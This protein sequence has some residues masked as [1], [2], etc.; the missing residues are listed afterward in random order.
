MNQEIDRSGYEEAFMNLLSNPKYADLSFYSF[1]IAK[2]QI[3]I[4]HSVPTAGAGFHNNNYQLIV[5]PDFFNPLPLEQ[6]MGILV[7]ETLHVILKHIFRKGERNHTLFNVA[8]DIALNQ[9]IKRSMLPEGALYPDTFKFDN[10]N[11]WPSGKTSEQYYELLKEEKEKQQQEKEDQGYG[12]DGDCPDCDG[13]GQQSKDEGGNAPGGSESPDDQ[14]HP[15]GTKPCETCNGSGKEPG[16][17]KPSN[18]NPD[19]TREEEITIDSH[20]LW[21][22]IS[23]DD[24]ELAS[25]MMEKM[26]ENAVEKS[27]GNTPGNME[28]ILNLW[29]R[30]AII[31]WKKVLKRFVSSKVGAKQGTI[32]RRDRRQPG[33][34]DLKGRKVSYDVA[35]V[36]VGIDTSGSMSDEEI[37]NGLVEINEVCKITHS[38]LEI[39][40][41]DTV[42]QGSEE[43]DPK[44][45][46]FKRRG[47]GGTYMGAMA[48]YLT[49]NKIKYDV[50]VM[51]SDMY[52]EDVSTDENWQKVKRPTLWLNTSGTTVDWEGL[53]KHTIMDIA[54]A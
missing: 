31:S 17:Y 39:V 52:I 26:I 37:L 46:T 5:N 42:I 16:G 24:E 47:C 15:E 25:Q 12:D 48:E 53:R 14:S 36:I 38:T 43:F 23:D 6:R 32:K 19:L 44:K 1:I 4:N 8:A 7:H 2:M 49:D 18:G 3:S 29:K 35:N 51:I 50:L 10:G 27:R 28:E 41:I 9:S 33:R 20:E 30:P 40:Q 13:T 11:V 22:N 34:A 45:K 54:K 21:D